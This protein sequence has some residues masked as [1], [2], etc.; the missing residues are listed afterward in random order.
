MTT[1]P[2]TGWQ[3]LDGKFLATE[4]AV[5]PE[6]VRDMEAHLRDML[7]NY[8]GMTPAILAQVIPYALRVTMEARGDLDANQI[9]SRTALEQRLVAIVLGGIAEG[10]T[11]A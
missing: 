5:T 1:D 6:R 3:H 8:D 11:Y 2:E 10:R 4:P 7:E 9:E